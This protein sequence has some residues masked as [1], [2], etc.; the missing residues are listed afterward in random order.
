M[1]LVEMRIAL[2]TT[3]PQVGTHVVV[4]EPREG[5]GAAVP[6]WIGQPEALA[7]VAAVQSI[8]MARPM[9]HDLFKEA[10]DAL[11]AKVEAVEVVSLR[12]GTYYAA[13]RLSTPSGPRTLDARPSDAMALAVRFGAPIRVEEEVIAAAAA[14]PRGAEEAGSPAVLAGEVTDDL[15]AS[16]TEEAFPK[17]KM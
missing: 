6:I 9:T 17:W 15:L 2:I 1:A 13:V 3:D 5:T 10:L 16:L 11:G 12:E 7:I 4:L 8:R 14:A